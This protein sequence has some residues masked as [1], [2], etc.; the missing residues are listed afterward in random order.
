MATSGFRLRGNEMISE[1]LAP[2]VRQAS[3]TAD[4]ALHLAIIRLCREFGEGN[5]TASDA[6]ALAS[7]TVTKLNM[8]HDADMRYLEM[9]R[10]D[11]RASACCKCL[12]VK[13]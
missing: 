6:V 12:G 3:E 7:I 9:D 11:R 5:F 1:Q 10:S 4:Y 2:D 8:M 13:K